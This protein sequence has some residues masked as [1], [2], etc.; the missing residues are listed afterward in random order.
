MRGVLMM[1][2]AFLSFL[3]FPPALSSIAQPLSINKRFS[4][5]THK[6]SIKNLD[7][8]L[9]LGYVARVVWLPRHNV[10]YSPLNGLQ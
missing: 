4:A 10:L 2:V 3:P 8:C 7:L 1:S 6:N 9:H 5:L